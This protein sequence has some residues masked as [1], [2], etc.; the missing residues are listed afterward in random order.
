MCVAAIEGAVREAALATLRDDMDAREL[1]TD[2]VT[3]AF[4]EARL[5]AGR[6]AA[7]RKA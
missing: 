1:R 4:H 5:A 7:A 3:S 6:V 2:L